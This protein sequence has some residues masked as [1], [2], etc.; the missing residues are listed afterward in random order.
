MNPAMICMWCGDPKDLYRG[1]TESQPH[2][3]KPGFGWHEGCWD[4]FAPSA[5]NMNDVVLR[6]TPEGVRAR[7]KVV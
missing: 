2:N 7:V 1:W 3:D 6:I 4:R 5:E